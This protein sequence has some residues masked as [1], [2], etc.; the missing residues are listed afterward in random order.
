VV[1][2]E[3]GFEHDGNM[4]GPTVLFV[5]ELARARGTT[6]AFPARPGTCFFGAPDTIRTYDLC[7]SGLAPF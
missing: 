4:S 7:P 2:A 1:V 6:S 5:L 3:I